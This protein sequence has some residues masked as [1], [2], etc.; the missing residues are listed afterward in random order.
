MAG[1]LVVDDEAIICEFLATLLGNEGHEV[2]GELNGEKALQALKEG[3]FD[4]VIT[5]HRME[6]MDGM[7]L[8]RQ[9]NQFIPGTP[10]IMISGYGKPKTVIDALKEG[11][12]DFLNK[13]VGMDVMQSTVSR[14]LKYKQLMA[15][16]Q[17]NEQGEVS[18]HYCLDMIIAESPPMKE[19]CKKI[20]Q[21]ASVETPVLLTGAE[22]TG[23]S[24]V[25][26]TIHRV[27]IR[28][29]YLFESIDCAAHNERELKK[30]LLAAG[31]DEDGEGLV[32]RLEGG[33]LH[34]KNIETLPESLQ[35]A[36]FQILDKQEICP[37]NASEE[38]AVNLR[39]IASTSVSLVKAVGAHTFRPELYARLARF[40]LNVKPIADRPE[41]ILPLFLHILTEAAEDP[42]RKF[43]LDGDARMILQNHTWPGNANEMKSLA[44][45]IVSRKEVNQ[46]TREHLPPLMVSSVENAGQKDPEESLQAA[47]AL[48][49]VEAKEFLKKTR[50]EYQRM[51]DR[52]ARQAERE[53]EKSEDSSNAG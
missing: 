44:Q 52:Q 19:I 17:V 34:F 41:D 27:G 32:F 16:H 46:I 9:I 29:E 43:S 36:L 13:P 35:T 12:F 8:L 7:E 39:M 21:V 2:H 3:H 47:E 49:G 50:E 38:K 33:S 48:K 5:D 4:L 28:S 23:K 1:I 11:A 51:L 26:E 40:T 45:Q 22:G 6:P 14:A 53:A 24:V 42:T 30:R 31:S 15:G 18:V 20:Q 37:L 25:A 10:V